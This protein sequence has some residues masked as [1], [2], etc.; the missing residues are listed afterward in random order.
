MEYAPEIKNR[1]RRVE[2]QIRGI[3]KMMED[4]KECK[5]VITQLTASRSAIDRA[6]GYILGKN[7]EQC[8][9][10]QQQMGDEQS[11]KLVDEAIEL[12]IKSK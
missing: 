9:V 3:L 7:L 4:E 10:I 11:T 8:I 12:L 1:L 2:G 6:V 5:D